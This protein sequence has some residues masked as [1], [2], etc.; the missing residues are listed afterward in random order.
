MPWDPNAG[1]GTSDGSGAPPP[2]LM[3]SSDPSAD[4][5]KDRYYQS[6]KDARAAQL[7]QQQSFVMQQDPG[8]ATNQAGRAFKA[9]QAKFAAE[10][11]ADEALWHP[12]TTPT[13]ATTAA[14]EVAPVTPPTW[15]DTLYQQH[16]QDSFGQTDASKGFEMAQNAYG[17]RPQL[18]ATPDLTAAYKDSESRAAAGINRSM[19]SRGSWGSSAATGQL[20]NS[21]SSMES[22]RAQKEAQYG[23]DRFKAGDASAQG[24]AST[25]SSAGIGSAAATTAATKAGFDI[26]GDVDTTDRNNRAET[27]NELNGVAKGTSALSSSL[28]M[29]IVDDQKQEITD[30]SALTVGAYV[31]DTNG[32]KYQVEQGKGDLAAFL[33]LVDTT[34][35]QVRS[36]IPK[37]TTNKDAAGNVTGTSTT[38]Y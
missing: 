20:A 38:G 3:T 37:T 23:L 29:T 22:D 34:T 13:A 10:D 27:Y 12:A 8:D 17:Q 26:A 4:P 14:P 11:A 33:Q 15:S 31:S 18:S 7:Q 30:A 21:M 9:L 5:G 19:A 6:R 2:T 24:W 32:K 35:G 1:W 25:L 16:G 36:V 28:G